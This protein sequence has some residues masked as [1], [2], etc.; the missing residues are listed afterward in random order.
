MILVP[1][2]S[3]DAWKDRLPDPD[4]QWKPGESAHS[5]AARW[6]GLTAFPPEVSGVL[7]TLNATRDATLLLAIPEHQVP[8]AGGARASQTDLWLLAR[9]SRGL[10]S[11]VVEGKVNE[12]FGPSV[13]DWEADATTGA[14]ERWAALCRLLEIQQP[15]NPSI[16][17]QLFHRTATALLEAR[18]FF[19]RGAA[20]VVHSF[21]RHCEGFGD[22]QH[23]VRVMGGRLERPGQLVSVAPRE[24]IEMFF[25]WAQGPVAT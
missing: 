19:A 18:R 9:T 12:S 17:Y 16:R 23:F 24:G 6:H 25:G 13:G 4:T 1:A 22:F 7:D 2:T 14:R 10:L 20:V 11:V 15:C 8:L 5:L 21:S 3:L